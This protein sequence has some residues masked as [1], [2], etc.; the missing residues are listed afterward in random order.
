MFKCTFGVKCLISCYKLLHIQKYIKFKKKVQRSGQEYRIKTD[1]QNKTVER[2]PLARNKGKGN[3]RVQKNPK[4]ERINLIIYPKE[5]LHAR[6]SLLYRRLV[7]DLVNLFRMVPDL[8]KN[9]L[10]N[11]IISQT[12]KEGNVLK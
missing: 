11:E 6:L 7:S 5:F 4:R 2:S 3:Q 10:F 12:H 1:L 8:T 9:Y